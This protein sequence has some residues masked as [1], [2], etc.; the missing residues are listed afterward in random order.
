M[1]LQISRRELKL[2]LQWHKNL[3]RFINGVYVRFVGSPLTG[4]GKQERNV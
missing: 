2:V 1:R 3:A 4:D